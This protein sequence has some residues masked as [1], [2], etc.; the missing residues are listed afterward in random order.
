[1]RAFLTQNYTNRHCIFC[2][3]CT[4]PY[5]V[6]LNTVFPNMVTQYIYI[7]LNFPIKI[8]P[9]SRGKRIVLICHR[10]LLKS[11]LQVKTNNQAFSP[12]TPIIERIPFSSPA[13]K[14]SLFQNTYCGVTSSVV[15]TFRS[16]KNTL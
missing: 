5:I 12:N 6:T 16:F 9:E 15:F 8:A 10:Y 3:Y 11:T 14:H 7:C 4:I 2:L 1:M 13:K